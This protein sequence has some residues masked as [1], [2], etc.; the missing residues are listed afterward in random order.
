MNPQ[1]LRLFH[2]VRIKGATTGVVGSTGLSTGL[3]IQRGK[4][5][6]NAATESLRLCLDIGV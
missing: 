2:C 5:E 6:L 4:Y 1:P 3:F